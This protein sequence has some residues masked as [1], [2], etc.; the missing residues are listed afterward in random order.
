MADTQGLYFDKHPLDEVLKGIDS[1]VSLPEV[2]IKFRQLMEDPHSSLSDLAKVVLCGPNLTALV[3]KFVNSPLF[4][5]S[6]SINT[7]S[8]AIE[9]LGTNRLHDLVLAATVMNLDYPD[10]LLPLKRFWRFSLF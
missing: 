7:I 3:L 6:G 4:G 5:F 10:T 9:L 8:V 2:Y 1:L